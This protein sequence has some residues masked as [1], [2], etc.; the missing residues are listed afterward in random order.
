MLIQ[1]TLEAYQITLRPL[2]LAL[3]AIP[4]AIAAFLIHS[5]RLLLLDRSLAAP[6]PRGGAAHDRRSSTSST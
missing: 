6:Q 5:A 3:W 1:Q 2:D 4:T